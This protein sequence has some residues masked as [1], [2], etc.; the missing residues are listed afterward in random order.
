MRIALLHYSAPP[1]IGG[2]E[3][4]IAHQARWMAQDGHRVSV[5]AGR[6]SHFDERIAFIR[7][8]L[9]DSIHPQIL[10]LKREL[11]RG[12]HPPEFGEVVVAL[13]RELSHH[14][15]KSDV[16]IAHNVCSLHLNLALTAAL[17]ELFRE[18]RRPALI[19]WHHDLAWA[20]PR[21]RKELHP[22]YPWDLLRKPWPG[23]VQ[24][25]A[26]EMR[27]Q[28]LAELLGLDV[29]QITV[30]PNGV[31]IF[32]F[33]KL[34]PSTQEYLKRMNLTQADPLLLLPARI[35]PRKNIELALRTLAALRSEFPQAQL[36][37]TGPLGAHNPANVKY[38]AQ[39]K[40]LRYELGLEHSAHFLAEVSSGYVPDAVI[41]DFYRLADALFFPSYE[42]GFGIPILE[43]ALAGRPIFC[44][45]IPPLRAL[46]GKEVTYFSPD[47]EPEEI[48]ARMAAY[49]RENPL[50]ILASR[51]RRNFSWEQIYR[52]HIL[53]ILQKAR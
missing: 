32:S 5:L 46:G 43:A 28:E 2:V 47:A 19:L 33:L 40:R 1:V 10:A 34:E 23:A 31:D 48:A 18:S 22:G 30:I 13:K 52:N 37:V 50:Y 25:A 42:E 4:V 27:R 12:H 9:A 45:D 11:D 14:L 44:S 29:E 7:L 39:L 3:S 38:F 51:V 41:A 21:Y 15:A 16:L 17:W 6:G 26:S 35:T 24:V 49:F 8:P 36:L 20:T 53:P